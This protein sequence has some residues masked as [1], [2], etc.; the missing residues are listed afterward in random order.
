MLYDIDIL[1]KGYAAERGIA[2]TRTESLNGSPAFTRT[3]AEVANRCFRSP[4]LKAP[5]AHP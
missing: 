3:L 2:L 1:F 5:D 4:Q